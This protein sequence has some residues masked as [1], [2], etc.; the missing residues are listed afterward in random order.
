MI[1]LAP[2]GSSCD[3]P[4]VGTD[5]SVLCFFVPVLLEISVFRFSRKYLEM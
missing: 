2:V 1:G 3:L 4:P 5:Y